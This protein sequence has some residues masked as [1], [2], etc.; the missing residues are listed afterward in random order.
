MHQP[1]KLIIGAA[2]LCASTAAQAEWRKFETEHFIVYSESNDKR[3]DELATGLE[4]TDGLMRMAT[5]LPA[6]GETVKVRIYE[7]GDEGQVQAAL[8]EMNSGVAGFYTSN[9]LGPYAVTER[10]A[11]SATGDFTAELI[12]HH[13]YAHHF[14]L[15]YFPG[16]YPSWYIEGFAELI[17]SSKTLP[18]GKIA[19]GWPATHRGGG[20]AA[21]WI[22]MRDVLLTPP[23]KLHGLDL[24]GQG[25]AMTHYLT[26]SKERSPELRRY[27]AALTAGK[28]PQEAVQAFGDLAVL[29]REAHAYLLNGVFDAHP[30]AVPIH[31]PVVQKVSTVGA[32]E[33]ALIPETIAFHDFDLMAVR[34]AG[35]REQ[36]LKHREKILAHVQAKAAQFP[37]DPYALYLLAQVENASG[38]KHAAAVAADRLL[39]IQPTHVGGMVVKS[40]LL[41][42]AASTMAGAARAQKAAE[43]RHLAML[44]NKEDPDNALTY[45]AF[46]KSYPA[47]GTPAPASAVDG[48]A[49]AVEKLPR[50]DDVRQMLVD[51]LANE[52]KFTAAMFALSPLANDPHDSPMRTAA[53]EKM[54][55]LK[56]EAAGKASAI[57]AQH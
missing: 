4:S 52:G 1:F 34:K 27:L 28:S 5:G 6:D 41:S 39:V 18:D 15:Q 31:Q 43:A 10:K 57:A 46:Y 32:A 8:G 51:E 37:N 33:A 12:L 40:L 55:K 17:G 9:A 56:E 38:D 49:A 14:M 36:E 45:V 54:A 16:T 29:D 2:V 19:Y 21:H 48:L 26:F 7:M 3:V 20:I 23:E 13:E 25:W 35:D 24:Y 22:N 47:A 53:R 11:Y 50:N 44:A 30:V 42:D